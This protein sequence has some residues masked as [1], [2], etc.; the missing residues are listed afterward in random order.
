MLGL[1]T[2]GLTPDVLLTLILSVLLFTISALLFWASRD[3][4]VEIPY[5]RNRQKGGKAFAFAATVVLSLGYP[6]FLNLL[7]AMLVL[8]LPV[9]FFFWIVP[10]VW[11]GV[12]EPISND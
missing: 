9:A 3:R 2:E 4:L 1:L 11:R 6:H 7:L 10:T 5:R 12:R 8:A